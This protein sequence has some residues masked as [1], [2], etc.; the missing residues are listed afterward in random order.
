MKA[1]VRLSLL[2]GRRSIRSL[3]TIGLTL[4]LG[5]MVIAT[6]YFTL[7]DLQW[8]AFLGGILFASI[9]S[10]ASQA[11]KAEWLIIRRTRQLER[12]RESLAKA[13]SR[14]RIADEGMRATLGR[15]RMIGD[16]LPA[17][18][19]YLD[20]DLRV[21]EHNQALREITRLPAEQIEGQLLRDVAGRQYME[22]LSRCKAP[23]A[24]E[25]HDYSLNWQVPGGECIDLRVRQL[26]FPPGDAHP[27]GFYVIM[28]PQSGAIISSNSDNVRPDPA[29]AEQ[30]AS[31]PV[32]PHAA[33]TNAAGETLYLHSL[34]ERL[35]AG[36][37][38]R[39][40]LVHAI[41]NDE[42]LLFAQKI[43]ALKP[44]SL[45]H[46]TY[47]ILLRLREE[48]DNLLP[49][50]G[51]IPVAEHYGLTEDID[52][53]VVRT[54]LNWSMTQRQLRPEWQIP[55]FCVNLSESAVANPEFARFVVN[56]LRRTGFPASQL[57]FEIGEVETITHHDNVDHFIKAVKPIK[58]RFTV[59]AF[60]GIKLTFAHL[61]GL[62]FDF[63]KIDGVI[64]QNIFKSPADQRRLKMIGDVCHKLGMRSIA[65]FVEDE[66]TI[67]ALKEAGIDYAQGFA[68]DRPGPIDKII[69]ARSGNKL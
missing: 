13:E 31:S 22:M 40:K 49:P 51:F 50:G 47:E 32:G 21:H 68:I 67:A 9:A 65:E 29:D 19:F 20:R 7:F 64:I 8:L 52:R 1:L 18:I 11:S 35:M 48:E 24:G 26:P 61:S 58:S 53:W 5:V 17:P 25:T 14:A 59:D 3:L 27:P 12:M 60:G 2:L 46:G 54:L 41:K 4:T 36:N 28:L 33:I 39:A 56:E 44:F 37:D 45:E 15:M 23:L 57:C 62:K 43:E 10:M 16:T 55:M 34:N 30:P 38:P 69:T 63:I 42:F 6:I 66:R